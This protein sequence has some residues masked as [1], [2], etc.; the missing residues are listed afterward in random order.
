MNL[1]QISEKIPLKKLEE[2][3]DRV[4]KFCEKEIE[5][6][7]KIFRKQKHDPP[8]ARTFPPLAG[9]GLPCSI[10]SIFCQNWKHFCICRKNQ[11]GQITEMSHR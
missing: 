8:L 3:Y 11:M 9:K 5:N 10:E 7:L 4:I 2:K 1:F 6:M